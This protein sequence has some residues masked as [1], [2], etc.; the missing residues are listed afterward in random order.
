VRQKRERQVALNVPHWLIVP[1]VLARTDLV[2]VMPERFAAAIAGRALVFRDL[3]FASDSF[4]WT[5]YWH[6]RHEGNHAIGWLR[7][8]LRTVCQ[9]LS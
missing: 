8:A 7:G 4:D 9:T 1:H 2:S 6:R 5:L 3:P